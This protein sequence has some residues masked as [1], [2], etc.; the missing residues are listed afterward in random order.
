[1]KWLFC[2]S[3]QFT[4][5]RYNKC[6]ILWI[7]VS[8]VSYVYKTFSL[9]YCKSNDWL[10]V[11][12]VLYFIN[13]SQLSHLFLVT[14]VRCYSRYKNINFLFYAHKCFF[15]LRDSAWIS[16]C[17]AK[18]TA[19]LDSITACDDRFHLRFWFSHLIRIVLVGFFHVET[20]NQFK[21]LAHTHNL[22]NAQKLLCFT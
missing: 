8:K 3:V 18:C 4:E 13:C 22:N 19:E 12:Y 16:L 17:S 14:R 11:I 21:M 7:I 1:M 15:S 10:E 2:A 5:R 6:L 9:K 20:F